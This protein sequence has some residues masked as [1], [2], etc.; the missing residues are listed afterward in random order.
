[1]LVLLRYLWASPNS[2]IG[3]LAALAAWLSGGKVSVHSGVVE[4]RGGLPA[5]CLQHLSVL[6][7]G[8]A[9]MTLGHVV[10]GQDQHCLDT[11]RFHER[12]HVRQYGVWGPFFLPAY[13]GTSLMARMRGRDGY[14][15][16]PFERE[17]FALEAEEERRLLAEARGEGSGGGGLA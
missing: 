16:N 8:I 3:L 12:V 7:R 4:V 10:I 2:A 9:A 6:P 5:W 1:M 11:T 13:L 17:A 14:R 15:E